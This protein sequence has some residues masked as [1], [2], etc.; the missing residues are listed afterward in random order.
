MAYTL[1]DTL[2]SPNTTT[3]E[4]SADKQLSWD[5]PTLHT[6][7]TPINPGKITGYKVYKDGTK[8]AVATTFSSTQTGLSHPVWLDS[9]DETALLV[10]PSETHTTLQS[11]LDVVT[12]GQTIYIRG[13]T[14]QHQTSDPNVWNVT[15]TAGSSGNEITITSYPGETAI[16]QGRA[17]LTPMPN[18][19]STPANGATCL[20]VEHDYYNIKN[21]TIK[22]HTKSGVRVEA[23]FC[24]VSFLTINNIWLNGV[25]VGA[26]G[27]ISDVTVEF[28][29]ISNCLHHSGILVGPNSQASSTSTHN[30]MTVRFNLSYLHGYM[31]NGDQVVPIAGDPAGGGNSDSSGTFKDAHDTANPG[32]NLMSGTKFYGNIGWSCADDIFDH[33]AGNGG[34]ISR[35][36]ALVSGP[37]GK[38]GYK[39]LRAIVGGL[40]FWGCIAANLQ[41]DGFEL[42]AEVGGQIPMYGITAVRATTEGIDYVLSDTGGTDFFNVV[43]ND[44]AIDD[45]LSASGTELTPTTSHLNNEGA[46]NFM[47]STD[48]STLNY[49][50]PAGTFWE[51]YRFIYNQVTSRLSPA[52]DGNL[53]QS[54]TFVASKYSATAIN[55]S[56]SPSD[57]LAIEIPWAVGGVDIGALPYQEI[58]PPTIKIEAIGGRSV[59]D[60]DSNFTR[61]LY[62]LRRASPRK[63]GA[64]SRFIHIFTDGRLL[65]LGPYFTVSEEDQIQKMVNN[66]VLA[67]EVIE[68]KDAFSAF[69]LR[70][71]QAF[72]LAPR[73]LVERVWLNFARSHQETREAYFFFSE[74]MP[75][76]LSYGLS[77]RDYERRYRLGV[78]EFTKIRLRW[79]HMASNSTTIES[80]QTVAEADQ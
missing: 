73:R 54:G 24:T 80:Y 79:Q 14:Y 11:A 27:A 41:A 67:G 43:S 5:I 29:D 9:F 4:I 12:A 10:G 50:L 71:K 48:L 28:N 64:R 56:A 69:R 45:D 42:R 26:A 35:E 62:S 40:E 1:F 31:V 66:Q 36:I 34:I 77:D 78:G 38:R 23:S 18:D 52:K 51:K 16:L 70:L 68:T 61:P 65:N 75:Q 44:N 15:K 53:Y 60:V 8:W 6:D 21:L 72:R 17:A 2:S 74:I 20:Q 13:G 46:A 7:G 47:G 49:T 19:G 37:E 22:D 59:N 63:G 32:E 58:L 55:D 3:Y 39:I 30:N 57:P 25:R 76:I 33:S